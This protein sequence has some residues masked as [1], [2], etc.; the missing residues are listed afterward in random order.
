MC[1]YRGVRSQVFPGK[2]MTEVGQDGDSYW[3]CLR[4][5]GT[6]RSPDIHCVP[7]THSL[8][9]QADLVST[10]KLLVILSSSSVVEVLL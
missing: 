10:D 3:L 9:N 4:T 6:P 8:V 2:Q 7:V 5:S 1:E